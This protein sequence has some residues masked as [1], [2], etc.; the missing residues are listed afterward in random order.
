MAGFTDLSKNFY[1]L[2]DTWSKMRADVISHGVVGVVLFAFLG[3]SFP[4]V[5][6]F[7][8]EPAKILDD[9]R[10]LLLKDT[11]L[12]FLLT[13]IPVGMIFIYGLVL[14]AV[15]AWLVSLQ[16][17][18]FSPRA[19]SWMTSEL[20]SDSAIETIALTL[21][22]E[23]FTLSDISQRLNDLT[24]KYMAQE[25][26][27]FDN[28]KKSIEQ[29]GQNTSVYLGNSSV[30]FLMWTVLFVI[31][32]DDH[33]WL[34]ANRTHF[35]PG[36]IFLLAFIVWARIRLT[37]FMG[38]FPQ[39][40]IAFVAQMARTDS[41]LKPVIDKARESFP[42]AW[43]RVAE[44]RA[45]ERKRSQRPSL[46]AFLRAR[47]GIGL[48]EKTEIGDRRRGR[49]FTKI[50]EIGARFS[51]D[52]QQNQEYNASWIARYMAYCYYRFHQSLTR[53][54][55]SLWRLILYFITGAP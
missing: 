8:I 19:E 37:R 48:K 24:L 33:P 29:S 40:Q 13:L 17:I 27:A 2:Q 50:F 32:P 51:W 41:E 16:M 10:F 42:G 14:R 39:I 49:P 3:V 52:T 4:H 44:I 9:S 23:D 35:F 18:L 12:F 53:S 30:F 21:N 5:A 11:G 15:G 6:F 54:L 38:F 36:A 47:L 43:E 22:R 20:V 25:K 46:L 1:T 7:S 55:K 28:F 26:T 34:I 31:L 45:E